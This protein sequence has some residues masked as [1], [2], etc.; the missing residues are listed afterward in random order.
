MRLPR[1]FNGESDRDRVKRQ[2]K[3]KKTP[4]LDMEEELIME[5]RHLLKNEEEGGLSLP[6]FPLI[7]KM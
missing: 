7:I 4:L 5:D 2:S 3:D 1:Q 6:T